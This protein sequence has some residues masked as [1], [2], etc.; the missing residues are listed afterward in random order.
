MSEIKYLKER[1]YLQKLAKSYAQKKPHLAEVLEPDDPQTSYLMEGFAFLSAHLQEKIDDAFPEITLPL[2][3]RLG[4]QAIKGLPST[5][6]IQ[7]SC[8]KEI[9]YSYYIPK[10][11]SALG[12]NNECFS[13]CRDLYIEPYSLIEKQVTHQPN[14][15]CISLTFA[16][17]GD[18]EQMQSCPLNLFLSPIKNIAD[19]LL[20]GLTQHFD[21]IE[22][23]HADQSYHGD[24][25]TFCFNSQIGKDY[26]IFPQSENTPKAPQQLLEGL[27]L[28]H[29]HHF[30]SLDIPVIIKQLDWGK[31]TQFT[32]NI[33]LNKQI[34]LTE[35]Q[36]QDCFLLNCIPTVDKE[37][38]HTVILDFQENKSSYLL[39]IP[40][41]HYL[42]SL[43]EIML[44]LEP[45]EK[46][47]GIYCHFYSITELTSASRLL[48]QYQ[49]S[50]F[51]SLTIDKDITGRTFY[52]VHFYDN[53]G[54][55]L[56][57]PPSLHFSCTY[58]G[59]EKYKDNSIGVLNAHSE[60]MPDNL[61]LKNITPLSE[62]FPPIVDDKC[63]WH[64]LSHYSANAFMLMS[65]TT[66]KNMLSDY[67]IYSELDK[68]ITR[69]IKKSLDGCI[70]LN[71]Q[72]YDYILKGKPHR[73]LSL[74]LTLD[75]DYFDNEGDAFIFVSHLYHFFPFCLSENML[76]EMKIKFKDNEKIKWFL[77][78]S[79]LKGYKSLL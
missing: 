75:T 10:N 37:K 25:T 68:Q 32:V 77:S 20:L 78:P 8:D 47:R 36:C 18:I 9:N 11:S 55:E 44:S 49:N 19:T 52:T 51:Y 16:Y 13:T 6:I 65:I 2:L 79:P 41:N 64:L 45:H 63:Y 21:Y 4:S 39:P 1:Q 73:C 14:K 67:L 70:D 71:S 40:D 72:T 26:P 5:S 56:I 58:I 59:F 42:S 29:V 22:L 28:P 69:K 3:Q 66:I 38:D 7:I 17:L 60:N 76:L 31:S 62:C 15:S 54:E 12:S 74:I 53:K 57:S 27:Y 46:E 30:I 23:K 50:L 48:P 33:Y 43:S 61:L 24:N 35:E 34:S